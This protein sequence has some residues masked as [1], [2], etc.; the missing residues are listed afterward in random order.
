MLMMLMMPRQRSSRQRRGTPLQ[1]RGQLLRRALDPEALV[2][3]LA[4]IPTHAV[5]GLMVSIA[6]QF[7]VRAMHMTTLE[8]KCDQTGTQ[9]RA[10]T[11]PDL[12]VNLGHCGLGGAV[13]ALDALYS[14]L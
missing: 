12:V 4:K 5:C 6:K 13:R 9:L 3:D 11:D 7:A 10:S 2:I 14:L 8:L 1:L